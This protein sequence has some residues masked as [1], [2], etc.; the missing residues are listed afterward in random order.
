MLQFDHIAIATSDL[1]TGT[2][3]IAKALGVPLQP[4]GKHAHYGT[5]NTLLGLGDIYL[6]VIAKDPDAPVK[7]YPTWFNLDHFSGPTRPANWICRTPDFAQAPPEVGPAVQLQRDSIRWELTVPDDGG[8]P[9]DGAYPSLLR[10]A[11]GI[12]PPAQSLPDRDCR[13]TSW[14]ISHP[15]AENIAAMVTIT[16]PRVSFETGPASFRAVIDTPTGPVTLA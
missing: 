15:D 6:E 14:N 9:F 4:G 2:A 12:T 11:P 3:E 16:D 13:L 5:H 10:W 1:A 8:L 7:T